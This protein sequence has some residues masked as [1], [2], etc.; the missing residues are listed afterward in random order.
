MLSIDPYAGQIYNLK[1]GLILVSH[2]HPD[3]N[4]A[5]RIQNRSEA[6][7]ILSNTDALVNGER[8]PLIWE[9][10]KWRLCMPGNNRN[11]DIHIGVDWLITL[12]ADISICVSGEPSKMDPRTE[13]T[14]R[15]IH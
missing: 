9:I 6:R 7:R 3:Q 13:P 5:D 10:P 4:A 1:A 12:S 14:K 15:D 11:H 2:D 8:G